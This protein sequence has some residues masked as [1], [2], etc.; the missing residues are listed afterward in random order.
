[1]FFCYSLPA[2]DAEQ[3]VFTLEAGPVRWYLYDAEADA[4][5]ESPGEIVESIRSN[6]K[7]PR[8]CTTSRKTLK[9]ARD[10][11]RRHIRDSYL[12][13][14]NAPMDAPEPKLRCWMELN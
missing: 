11:V 5:V 14:V 1:M 10:R 2:L 9:E 3:G 7:T 12:K 8:R 4:I 6:P 13:R